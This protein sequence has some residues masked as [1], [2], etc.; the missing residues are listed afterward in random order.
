MFNF[1]PF[2]CLDDEYSDRFMWRVGSICPETGLCTYWIPETC[3][4]AFARKQDAQR[5]IESLI[6]HGITLENIKALPDDRF[7]QIARENLS[8]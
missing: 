8:W 7:K 5:A 1:F 6:F 3:D 2:F 4:L